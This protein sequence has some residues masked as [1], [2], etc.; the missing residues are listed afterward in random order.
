[1]N[2]IILCLLLVSAWLE[3]LEWKSY[4]E[5]LKI[6]KQNGKLIMIDVMRVNC[7]YCI[8]MERDVMQDDETSV[9][10]ENN[11]IPV[12]INIDNDVMPLGIKV[13]F[14]PSFYFINEKSEI[15]KKIPGAWSKEDFKSLLEPLFVK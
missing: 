6:Q 15:V 5:A 1:M 4:E 10:I 9:W 13:S 11:F 7:H 2:K 12:K 3:A 8:N 14:T